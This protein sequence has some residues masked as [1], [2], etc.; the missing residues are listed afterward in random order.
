MTP[1]KSWEHILE[2]TSAQR[3]QFFRQLEFFKKR[4]KS[5]RRKGEI[6]VANSDL[7]SGHAKVLLQLSLINR[8]PLL[9]SSFLSAISHV[10]WVLQDQIFASC[11]QLTSAADGSCKPQELS[12]SHSHSETEV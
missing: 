9:A 8:S 1:G 12:L 7:L 4:K 11:P 6:C 3:K 5:E 2:E 10:C